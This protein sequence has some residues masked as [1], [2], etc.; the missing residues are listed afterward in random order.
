[1]ASRVDTRAKGDDGMSSNPEQVSADGADGVTPRD[2]DNATEG[3]KP[4]KTNESDVKPEATPQPDDDGGNRE[5][6]KLRSALEKERE[7]R[8]SAERRLRE[9]QREVELANLRRETVVL[10]ERQHL[11]ADLEPILFRDGQNLAEREAILAQV[12]AAMKQAVNYVA[13][14]CGRTVIGRGGPP[15]E[16]HELSLS[17]LQRKT[18][19]Y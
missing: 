4:D 3:V 19:I 6:E 12:Y 1:M 8:K 7:A 18:G 5:V 2:G 10:L 9:H 17:E 16:P 15:D 14:G 11:P 13:P